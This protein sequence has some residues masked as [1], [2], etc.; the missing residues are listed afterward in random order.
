[1]A[2]QYLRIGKKT[3]RN[4]SVLKL[5]QGQDPQVVIRQKA[6]VRVQDAKTKGWRGPPF[7]PKILASLLGIKLEES[8]E[9][10]EA[11]LVPIQAG[12]LVIHYN[13]DKPETRQNFSLC[14]EIAHTF[15]PD[16]EETIWH[17][18][19]RH[20]NHFD[21]EDEVCFLCDI[22]ASELL[23]PFPEFKNSVS[24]AGFSIDTI[25]TLR[26]EYKASRDAVAIRMV[27]T[28]LQT[29]AVVFYE[30][31]LKPT[32]E[33]WLSRCRCQTSL[34]PVDL[35]ALEAKM[36]KLRVRFSVTSEDFPH[37][38]PRHKSV[39]EDSP[40]DIAGKSLIPYRGDAV[41]DLGQREMRSYVEALPISIND[42]VRV[43]VLVLP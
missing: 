11:M 17:R 26:Q 22:G 5:A 15:F 6:R 16:Y 43:I 27:D 24:K 10:E 21:P 32:E 25:E 19:K 14:H 28:G 37:F 23:L 30:G 8:S 34:F 39:D 20:E 18:G 40:I 36:E 7:D 41:L 35:E 3:Y 4:A 38:I 42:D 9:V 29:C 13:P 2:A 33:I 12:R 1:M 31:R